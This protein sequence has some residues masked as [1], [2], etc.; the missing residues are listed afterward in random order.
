MA[1]VTV[2]AGIGYRLD[3]HDLHVPL[4][5]HDTRGLESDSLLILPMVKATLEQGS[6]WACDRLGAPGTQELYDFPVVDHFHF[7]W[8]WLLGRLIPDA[9]LVFNLYY[10]LTFPLTALTAMVVFRHFGLSLPASAVGGIL[11]SFAPYHL[12][13]GENH[14]FLSAYY[15]VPFSLMLVLWVCDGRLPFF[16][17][18][19]DGVRRF[20]LTNRDTLLALLIAVVTATA[21]AYYAFFACILL[22]AA[23]AYGWVAKRTWKAAASTVLLAGAVFFVGVVQHVPTFIYQAKYGKHTAPTDRLAEEAE[24]Y[25]L[26]L[27]QLVLPIDDHSIEPLSFLKSTYNSDFRPVQSWTERYSLGTVGA[28]G[29]LMLLLRIILPLP[30]G[31]PYG[32]LTAM[33]AAAVLVATIGGFGAVFNHVVS[34]QVRCY[35]R[36]AIYIAFLCLFA[37]LYAVDGLIRRLADRYRGHRWK[38]WAFP[39]AAWIGLAWFGVWDQTPFYWGGPKTAEKQR[40]Q[41]ERFRKDA[42]FFTEIEDTLNPKRETP[43]PMVFQLPYHGWPEAIP[44]NNLF[45]YEH[46]RGY[47]HTATLRWSYGCMKG[48]EVDEWYRR[49]AELVSPAHSR[50]A[51][52]VLLEHVVKA[53]FEGLILDKRGYNPARSQVI[54]DSISAVLGGARRITHADGNQVFF[55]L[56][57]YRDWVRNNYGRSWEVECRR[58]TNPV[59]LLWLHGFI[60][61]KE[62]GYEWHHRWCA[63]NGLAVFVNP[64]NETR[65]FVVHFH[66]R[67]ISAHPA[68]LTI[69]GGDVWSETL[70]IDKYSPL[71]ERRFVVPPGRHFV[72]FHCTAPD[73]YVPTDPR[74]LLFFIA[75][76][77]LD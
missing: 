42:T 28:V 41:C 26:K 56:R 47:I 32:P 25:G 59:S 51:A 68:T 60:S 34:P 45:S 38:G 44:V 55:D 66:V 71:L 29:F 72:H 5:Y 18:S 39:A 4:L 75:G 35:N 70:T 54:Y 11:Y 20:R 21:G 1:V 33:T 37:V 22:V 77:K 63:E 31:W 57:P 24:Y 74:R 19:A 15:V 53:G 17:I 52:D 2:L 27:S 12:L 46:A 61:F 48:R 40:D 50:P 3:V 73:D 62:P 10:F 7:L 16:P 23:G 43:G 8:I 69:E 14:Y 64:T 13:R 36:I 67:T 30:R 49:V 76:L 9:V 58:E 6:H 65:E